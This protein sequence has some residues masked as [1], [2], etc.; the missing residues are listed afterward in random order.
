[1]DKILKSIGYTGEKSKL[2]GLAFEEMLEKIDKS[3]KEIPL[4][5][6][7]EGFVTRC[8]EVAPGETILIEK[9]RGYIIEFVGEYP[10]IE[11]VRKRELTKQEYEKVMEKYED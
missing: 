7:D 8:N 10:D 9:H 6:M 2:D 11:E 1:M 4:C 3:V 5:L